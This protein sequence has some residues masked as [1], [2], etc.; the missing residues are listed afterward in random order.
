MLKIRNRKEDR[1]I[2][3]GEIITLTGEH[4]SLKLLILLAT[5]PCP[6]HLIFETK[7]NATCGVT[8]SV[9]VIQ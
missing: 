7:V 6:Y 9:N 2:L 3:S 1:Y 5:F 8:P 4:L